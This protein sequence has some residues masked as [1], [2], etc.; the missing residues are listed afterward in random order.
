MN[1]S[2]FRERDEERQKLEGKERG[3]KE[4]GVFSKVSEKHNRNQD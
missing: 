2:N 4:N 3:E 1:S